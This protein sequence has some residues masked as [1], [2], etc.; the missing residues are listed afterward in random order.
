[1][2][3]PQPIIV[4]TMGATIE[5]PERAQLGQSLGQLLGALIGK[6]IQTGRE[7]TQQEAFRQAF[8]GLFPKQEVP[9]AGPPTEAGAMPQAEVTPPR[10]GA[11]AQLLSQTPEGRQLGQQFALKQAMS[12]V[13]IDA[14]AA[15]KPFQPITIVNKKTGEKRLVLPTFSPATGKARL[16]PAQFPE[17]FE[18]SKETPEEK[19]AADLLATAQKESQKIIGKTKEERRSSAIERGIDLSDGFATL[20]R[21]RGLLDQIKTG[22]FN[23]IALRAK[24]IFG[25][26]GANEAELS[27]N[28]GK[29][30][31]S[32]LRET[33]GAQFTEREGAKLD[34][35][36]AG[37]GKS[38][39]GNKRLLDQ[40]IRLTERAARR[41]IEAAREIG[42]KFAIDT[43]K[44]NLAFTLE[45]IQQ[46][47]TVPKDITKL[48]TEELLA[49]VQGQ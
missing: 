22:G 49:I 25:V 20:K 45:P 47:P 27:T 44:E 42:D 35:I 5:G 9:A 7:R 4:P 41:G 1:M 37:F 40:V 8:S 34:R 21:A 48:S 33:F 38:T 43:I 46:E 18:I 10:I 17:G 11:L 2:A 29:A 15:E 24:Q 16:E 30:V 14:K 39:E 31:L 3:R 32:Q 13:G 28:L 36:E 23:N 19:R 12:G 6:G 26:E